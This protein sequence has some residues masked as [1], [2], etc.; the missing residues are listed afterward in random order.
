MEIITNTLLVVWA[1]RWL[2]VLVAFALLGVL[3]VDTAAELRNRRERVQH[4]EDANRRLIAQLA[5]RRK[6]PIISGR[7]IR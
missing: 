1:L 6:R 5:H 4:L 3:Y 2:I 7:V